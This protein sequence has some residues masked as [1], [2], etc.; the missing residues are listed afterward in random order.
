MSDVRATLPL[1]LIGGW[2]VSVNMV[3]P[4]VTDWPAPVYPVSLDD[5][6]VTAA[7]DVQVAA[8]QLLQRLPAPAI[9]IGWS[10]GGQVAMAAAAMAPGQ[11]RGV[12][13]LC[14]FPRFEAAEDWPYGMPEDSF[15]QFAEGLHR[16]GDRHWK[17]FLM[18]QALGDP[19]EAA[20]R[21]QL[22]GWLE[23]GPPVAQPV[24][25]RSLEWLAGTDQRRL[26]CRLTVPALHLWGERDHVVNPL[27]ATADSAPQAV[28]ECIA[29]MTHWP[30]DEAAA[31]CREQIDNFSRQLGVSS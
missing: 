8:E 6:L 14:S 1:V 23:A 29:G 16:D 11:V 13:T 24:L 21:L 25:E 30:R 15:R 10:L 22:K 19:D 26:W 31:R 5:D 7:A 12:V 28:T 18:L 27:M 9:W 20:A 17:R 3:T 4:V 2:G